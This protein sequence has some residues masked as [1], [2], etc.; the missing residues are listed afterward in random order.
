MQKRSSKDQSDLK[1]KKSW[2]FNLFVDHEYPAK[3]FKINRLNFVH[4]AIIKVCE[5]LSDADT[6]A[7]DSI[8]RR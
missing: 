4:S 8:I 2:H 5:P 7:K 3:K 1:K 6:H